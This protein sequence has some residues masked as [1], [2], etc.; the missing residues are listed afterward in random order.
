[1]NYNQVIKFFGGKDGNI[2]KA[3]AAIGVT[4][5]TIFNWRKRGIPY[6]SQLIV[7]EASKGKLK[8]DKID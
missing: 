5:P 8:A 6:R 4:T 7:Q 3:A 2:T 1:M